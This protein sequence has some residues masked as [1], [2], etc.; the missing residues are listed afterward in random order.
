M[1]QGVL[2]DNSKA[3]LNMSAQIRDEVDTVEEELPRS[4]LHLHLSPSKTTEK[5]QNSSSDA[6][7]TVCRTPTDSS[8][9][10]SLLT[11]LDR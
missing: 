4:S 10:V 2:S 1:T 3:L 7:H 9:S 6:F 5:E 8:D 11:L